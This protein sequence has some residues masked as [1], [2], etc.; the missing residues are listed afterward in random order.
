MN[1]A[2]VDAGPDS[3]VYIAIGCSCIVKFSGNI[4]DLVF[5]PVHEAAD[6]LLTAAQ[7]TLEVLNTLSEADRPEDSYWNEDGDGFIACAV[8]HQ[9]VED[10]LG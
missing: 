6:D 3:A 1:L 7:M 2:E 5:C 10:A 4:A 9:A 8:T